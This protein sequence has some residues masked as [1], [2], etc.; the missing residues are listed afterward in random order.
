MQKSPRPCRSLHMI[1]LAA[2]LAFV[3]ATLVSGWLRQFPPVSSV[4]CGEVEDMLERRTV[5]WYSTGGR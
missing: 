3:S 2:I 5:G 1:P 4:E